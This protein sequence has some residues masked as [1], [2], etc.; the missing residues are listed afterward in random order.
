MSGQEEVWGPVY[1]VSGCLSWIVIMVE[2][3]VNW[4]ICQSAKCVFGFLLQLS[5]HC[6]SR[7]SI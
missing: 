2:V 6:L 4:E 7:Y 5:S 3:R 1:A